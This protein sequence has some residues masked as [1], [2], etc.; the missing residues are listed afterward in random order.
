MLEVSTLDFIPVVFHHLSLGT[1]RVGHGHAQ[2]PH[3]NVEEP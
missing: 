1:Q 2:D 3:T